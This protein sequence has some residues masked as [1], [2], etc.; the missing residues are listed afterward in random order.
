MKREIVK[1]LTNTP[2]NILNKTFGGKKS[3]LF[4]TAILDSWVLGS[5][6]FILSF[7]LYII[8]EKDTKNK[9][10]R[11]LH[12][13]VNLILYLSHSNIIEKNERIKRENTN[14]FG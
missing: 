10:W 3:K 1:H 4:A 2:A 12:I 5:F 11:T 8:S 13:K 9:F 6:S 7:S 14:P